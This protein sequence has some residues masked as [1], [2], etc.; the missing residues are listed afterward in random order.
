MMQELTDL[1]GQLLAAESTAAEAVK[2][3]GQLRHQLRSAQS[4]SQNL[5]AVPDV[6]ELSRQTSSV[7]DHVMKETFE[8]LTDEFQPS[9]VYKVLTV[10]FTSCLT[11]IFDLMTFSA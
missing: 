4:R 2:E 7:F 11:P 1:R 9:V 6:A 5:I 8:A 10:A 3:A